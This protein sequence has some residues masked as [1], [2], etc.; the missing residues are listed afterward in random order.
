MYIYIY[1]YLGLGLLPQSRPSFHLSIFPYLPIFPSAALVSR[2][3]ESHLSIFPYLSIFPSAALVRGHP[4]PYLSISWLGPPLIAS[5]CA[6]RYTDK[7]R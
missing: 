2:L 6:C 5:I 1:I 4:E 3:T 7:G